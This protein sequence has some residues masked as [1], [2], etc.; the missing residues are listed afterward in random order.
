[1][2]PTL[3]IIVPVYKVEAYLENCLSS[4]LNQT[5]KDFE[6]ILVNDGSPDRSGMICDLFAEKDARIKVIHQANEGPS[7]AR[8]SGLDIARG[9]YIGFV[10]SDDYIH[11]EMYE[12]LFELIKSCDADIS[13][14]EFMRVNDFAAA[15]IKRPCQIEVLNN[16]EALNNLY[17]GKYTNTVIPVN[18]VYKKSLFEGIRYPVGKIHEDDFTTYKLLY[19]ARKI[20]NINAVLY[21]YY[22]SRDSIMRKRFNASRL[23][24]LE[25]FEERRRFFKQ[26]NL[27]KLYQATC[28]TYGYL[29]MMYYFAVKEQIQGSDTRLIAMKR[30]FNRFLIEMAEENF[31]SPKTMNQFVTFAMN[32][33][34]KPNWKPNGIRFNQ[35]ASKNF[36]RH[37]LPYPDLP[38]AVSSQNSN[39]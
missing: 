24:A 2:S 17:N 7:S 16:I 26:E 22:Q 30:D 20:V 34:P 11:Q 5:F 37:R 35:S 21:F 23:D 14:C 39:S 19:K 4:I 27:A 38:S 18:K 31:L 29:Q 1:M 33:Y 36:T 10:D 12:I 3:S 9:D 32:H 25:A 15:G 8:N 13:Q 28:E 6:L